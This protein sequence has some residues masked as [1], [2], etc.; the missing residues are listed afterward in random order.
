[1]MLV[2]TISNCPSK[3]RGD[4]TKW[5][6]E[7]DT[8]VFVGNLNPRVRDAVWQR[9]GENIGNGRATMVFGTNGEQKLKFRIC[10]SDWVPVD[11]DGITLVKRILSSQNNEK[12]M[13]TKAEVNHINRLTQMKKTPGYLETYVVIDIETTGLSE[14]DEI[15]ELGA[16]RIWKG[17]IIDSWHI[18]TK[19]GKIIPKEVQELTGIT[20]DMLKE[21]GSNI[22]EALRRFLD[23]CAKDTLVGF[24]IGFDIQFLQRT[25]EKH[26]LNPISNKTKDV[27]RMARRKIDCDSGYS[28]SSVAME[29]GL[30]R[31]KLHRVKEDCF[32]TYKVFEKL[33]EM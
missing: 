5:L 33:N 1:M 14:D 3:L 30:E 6:I 26:G 12:K 17:E 29:L 22:L 23:F 10:N 18:L 21:E 31:S 20:N 27:L 16:L 24:N 2:I 25:I 11:F 9:I 15:I 19:C 8:G 28:L 13:S 7:I 32:L 4:L